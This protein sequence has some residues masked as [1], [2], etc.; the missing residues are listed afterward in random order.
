MNIFNKLPAQYLARGSRA[1]LAC[2]MTILGYVF[3][4]RDFQLLIHLKER[5]IGDG[6]LS[7]RERKDLTAVLV[8]A[9]LHAQTLTLEP[10]QE[11]AVFN[12]LMT[13]DDGEADDD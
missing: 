9:L 3:G 6:P 4:P 8:L 10:T 2:H 12:R 1:V 5:M 7:E 11:L 13:K